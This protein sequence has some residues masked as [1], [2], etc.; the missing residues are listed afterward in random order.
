M[1]VCS[2]LSSEATTL[3]T[4]A[5]DGRSVKVEAAGAT[6]RLSWSDSEGLLI[7]LILLCNSACVCVCFF[8]W[9]R[10]SRDAASEGQ[11]I[12]TSFLF[13]TDVITLPLDKA[14]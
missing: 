6:L 14:V 3:G 5:S 13:R 7:Q 11:T 12:R 8:S 4:A 2:H 9:L 1:Q 10:H